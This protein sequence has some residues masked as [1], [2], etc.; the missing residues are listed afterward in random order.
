[1]R[2]EATGGPRAQGHA[3]GPVRRLID[4]ED[5]GRGI[6]LAAVM[7]ALDGVA[8]ASEA[9]RGRPPDGRPAAASRGSW[10]ARASRSCFPVRAPRMP[11]GTRSAYETATSC[12]SLP[13]AP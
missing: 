6:A 1:M 13:C 9:E 4:A 3:Q 10:K 8:E 7:I 12:A 2:R 5:Q 11:V